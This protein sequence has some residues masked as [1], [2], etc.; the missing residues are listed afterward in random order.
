MIKPVLAAVLVG[1]VGFE[2]DSAAQADSIDMAQF[3]PEYS[4]YTSYLSGT[5]LTAVTDD[6]VQ[7]NLFSSNGFMSVIQSSSWAG[8]FPFGTPALVSG[9]L[10]PEGTNTL[11]PGLI[12]I[13]FAA[14]ITTFAIGAESTLQGAFTETMT[15]Y[16]PSGVLL[17]SV[18]HHVIDEGVAGT[19]TPMTLSFSDIGV[20]EIG[21][22]NDSLGFAIAGVGAGAVPEPATWAMMLAG[23]AGLGAVGYRA[24]RSRASA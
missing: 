3:L 8:F 1:L 20:V 10:N 9:I 24:G 23:F 16:D 2:F 13:A 5:G 22:S 11:G 6:G 19:W 17:G 21:V 15:A 14:P 18:S 12:T 4:Y 7:A